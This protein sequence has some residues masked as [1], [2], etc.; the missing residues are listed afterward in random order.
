M[1]RLLTGQGKVS[2]INL[3]RFE[4]V[5]KAKFALVLG[6]AEKCLIDGADEELQM[7]RILTSVS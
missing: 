2:N 3:N 4:K 6:K 5:Q 1:R 7:L